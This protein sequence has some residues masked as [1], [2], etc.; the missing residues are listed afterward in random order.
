MTGTNAGRFALITVGVVAAL[1]LLI[2]LWQVSSTDTHARLPESS[3]QQARAHDAEDRR[4]GIVEP[5]GNSRTGR[6]PGHADTDLQRRPRYGGDPWSSDRQPG[7]RRPTRNREAGP[8]TDMEWA[9]AWHESTVVDSRP[10]GTPWNCHLTVTRGVFGT[11]ETISTPGSFLCVSAHPRTEGPRLGMLA[12][13]RVIARLQSAGKCKEATG[14]ALQG[15]LEPEFLP[16]CDTISYESWMELSK[17]WLELPPEAGCGTASDTP[18]GVFAR[19]LESC[20]L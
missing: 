7:G 17:T 13:A 16:S 2:V 4:A 1:L 6:S 11:V 10:G 14:A 3:G 18:T 12:W 20:D 19:I 15:L 5:D 8:R 9:V